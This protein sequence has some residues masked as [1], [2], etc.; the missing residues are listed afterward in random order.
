MLWAPGVAGAL[1]LTSRTVS[2]S[3]LGVSTTLSPQSATVNVRLVWPA[4]KVSAP[5]RI[6]R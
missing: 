4:L 3:G 6:G 2:V 5:S 1:T